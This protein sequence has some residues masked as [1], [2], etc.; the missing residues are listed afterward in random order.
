MADEDMTHI[1][2]IGH[3]RLISGRICLMGV[4]MAIF[5]LNSLSENGS[6]CHI[7]DMCENM[8]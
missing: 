4:K 1:A 3:I 8:S 5:G 7:S 6:K 2:D